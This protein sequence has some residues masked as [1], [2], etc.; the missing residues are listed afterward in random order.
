[1]PDFS[2][3][4]PQSQITEF[5]HG[6]PPRGFLPKAW[7]FSLSF[8]PLQIGGWCFFSLIP[9]GVWLSHSFA[10]PM[11]L[12]LF[13]IR[14]VTG[15]LITLGCRPFCSR[16]FETRCSLLR[17]FFT[18]LL[19]SLVIGLLEL[20]GSLLL[21]HL[22]G[23][24]QTDS[25]AQ[26]IVSAMLLMRSGLF[27]IWFVLYFSLKNLR[28]SVELERRTQDAELQLLRSQ[29]NPHF[30][31][32][33]L[34]TIMEVGKENAQVV[35]V[36]QSL[37]EYL[38]FSLTQG[39]GQG[40][41]RHALNEELE[42]LRRYLEVEKARFHEDLEYAFEVEEAAGRAQ[43]PSA[44]VQPLLENA[45]KYGQRTSAKPLRIHISASITGNEPSAML[46]LALSNTGSWVEPHLANSLGTGTANLRRRL[47]LIYGD[48]ASL[49]LSHAEGVVTACVSLPT[50]SLKAPTRD[51]QSPD[52]PIIP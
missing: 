3:S 37:C 22:L 8:W 14:P 24:Q 20:Q 27:F 12:W 4:Q 47:Q 16:I 25:K 9:I 5:Q 38:R 17:L 18:I 10:D 46:H 41:D 50:I 13:L 19:A 49:K 32:N 36:T 21:G 34:T 23:I 26:G 1:M 2:P 39:Q 28:R 43:V 51:N 33:A 31:F 35:A 15:F 29:V 52:Q 40:E 42:A 7:I 48:D 45:I 11:V 6:L 44:L 30:L